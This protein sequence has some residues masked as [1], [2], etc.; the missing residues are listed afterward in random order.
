MRKKPAEEIGLTLIA[1]FSWAAR[2]CFFFLSS[3]FLLVSVIASSFAAAGNAERNAD[4]FSWP[5][6]MYRSL[7]AQL[8]LGIS[9]D[10]AISV[11][12]VKV[13]I[14]RSYERKILKCYV[15]ENK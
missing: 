6:G 12:R 8:H 5:L 9:V 10:T 3:F 11:A 13:F 2:K 4:F 15:L 1:L 7:E 14:K